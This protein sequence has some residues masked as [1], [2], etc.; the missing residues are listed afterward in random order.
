MKEAIRM[1]KDDIERMN[2]KFKPRLLCKIF[3]HRAGVKKL[4][5]YR[6]EECRFCHKII[7]MKTWREFADE[8]IEAIKKSNEMFNA[9]IINTEGWRNGNEK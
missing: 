5:G 6:V 9:S 7:R 4:V 1:T 8:I 3:G 2:E